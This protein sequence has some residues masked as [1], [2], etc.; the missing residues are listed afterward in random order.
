MWY[1]VA[2]LLAAIAFVPLPWHAIGA[3]RN[4]PRRSAA[5][6]ELG[7]IQYRATSPHVRRF[8]ARLAL[9]TNEDWRAVERVMARRLSPLAVAVWRLL[10]GSQAWSAD[11]GRA[12]AMRDPE[13]EEEVRRSLVVIFGSDES[14]ALYYTTAYWASLALQYRSTLSERAFR[15]AYEPFASAVPLSQ[16]A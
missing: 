1:L 15:A 4:A 13:A 16:L 12:E 5:P 9:F 8:L 11:W 7:S 2:G 6:A 14:N 10:T 3:R